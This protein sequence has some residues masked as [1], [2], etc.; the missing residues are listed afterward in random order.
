MGINF[1]CPGCGKILSVADDKGGRQGKCP[2]CD[3]VITVP[4]ADIE[5]LE[6]LG[7]ADMF[8]TQLRQRLER[9][10]PDAPILR[11]PA[12]FEEACNTLLRCA[13]EV[14]S[15]A[16]DID[17]QERTT[18]PWMKPEMWLLSRKVSES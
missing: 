6:T 14:S 8:Q 10:H 13:E 18:F 11:E 17:K 16:A 15:V 2:Q 9:A 12:R 4:R 5:R 1:Q 3:L 7:A